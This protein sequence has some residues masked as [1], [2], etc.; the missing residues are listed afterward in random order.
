MLDRFTGMQVFVRVAG[1]GSFSAAGRALGLSQTMVTK[2]VQALEDRLGTR[3]FHRST[4]RLTL[5]E[6]GRRHLEFCERILAEI[7]EAE[8]AAVAERVEPRGVLRVAAPVVF[9]TRE[10]APLLAEFLALY[11]AISIDIGFND[12]VVDLIE[13]GWDVAIRIA[14]LAESSLVARRLAPCNIALCAAS[15]Y[16]ARRGVPRT[17]ADLA[18][19]ECLGYTLPSPAAAER[20]VFGRNGE[21]SV[22]VAGRLRASNGEALRQAALAGVGL[23]NQ[24]T[25]IVGDDIRAGRLVMVALDRPQRTSLGVYAIQSS[26]RNPPAKVRAFVDFLKARFSPRPPWDRGLELE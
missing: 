19:H 11:P 1:L 13:E 3:L 9:G 23:I 20:W 24:P 2:H 6:A 15:S 7:D 22:P 12:R 8:Q 17:A 21:I 25:F 26:G 16:L 14:V 5:T 18:G 4:R 10:I